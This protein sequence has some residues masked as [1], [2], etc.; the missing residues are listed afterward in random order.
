MWPEAE[1]NCRPLIFQIWGH[2]SSLFHF[3]L[4]FYN[5]HSLVG[6]ASSQLVVTDVFIDNCL[7]YCDG[8]HLSLCGENYIGQRTDFF[9]DF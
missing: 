8:D 4:F 6:P 9:I 5:Y 3:N 2:L 1:S 7:I